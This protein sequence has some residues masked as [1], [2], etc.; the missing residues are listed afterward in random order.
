MRPAARFIITP[1]DRKGKRG[2]SVFDTNNIREW[3]TYLEILLDVPHEHC[4][5]V[6]VPARIVKACNAIENILTKS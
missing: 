1:S 5:Q 6:N 3:S 4:E 2:D